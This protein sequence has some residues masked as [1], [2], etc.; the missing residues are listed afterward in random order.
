MKVAGTP[1]YGKDFWVTQISTEELVEHSLRASKES[2]RAAERF[3]T[4]YEEIQRRTKEASLGKVREESNTMRTHDWVKNETTEE[5][6][7]EVERARKESVEANHRLV[8][9]EEELQAREGTAGLAFATESIAI[10]GLPGEPFVIK[11][12]R[13]T[14][15]EENCMLIVVIPGATTPQQGKIWHDML[16]PTMDAIGIEN[17]AVVP[18]GTIVQVVQGPKA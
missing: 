17:F 16:N 3:A 7:T 12:D 14:I 8:A 15:V 4:I 13:T 2:N 6:K 10:K 1:V 5:L 9:I 11:S 18:E